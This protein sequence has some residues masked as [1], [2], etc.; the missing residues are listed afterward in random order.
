MS[1]D[2]VKAAMQ[3]RGI[4]SYRELARQMGYKGSTETRI[5]YALRR[6]QNI[7]LWMWRQMDNVLGF[8]A[9]EWD[10]LRRE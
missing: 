4:R 8:T 1:A 10:R 2:V 9:E 3:R 7:R 6:P 5:C